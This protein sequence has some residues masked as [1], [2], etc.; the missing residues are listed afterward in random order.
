MGMTLDD[1]EWIEI[2]TNE[3]QV[4]SDCLM[5][6]REVRGVMNE[7]C[8]EVHLAACSYRA[9]GEIISIL[10]SLPWKEMRKARKTFRTHS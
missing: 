2:K 8:T 1:L 3:S 9:P 4:A 5:V 10:L 7:D 6:S